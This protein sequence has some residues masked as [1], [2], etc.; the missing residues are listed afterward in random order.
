MSKPCHNSW[1]DTITLAFS[2]SP[3]M[4]HVSHHPCSSPLRERQGRLV[5][6]TGAATE[7]LMAH[8]AGAQVS[9]RTSTLP[10]RDA[11]AASLSD[12]WP[13]L[14]P[15]SSYGS[16]EAEQEKC[17]PLCTEQLS[18][19]PHGLPAYL[20]GPR[21]PIPPQRHWPKVLVCPQGQSA[22]LL[23]ES[24]GPGPSGT[25]GAGGLHCGTGR[26]SCA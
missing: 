3:L 8:R 2:L 22:V 18:S 26:G 11:A 1:S 13:P 6:F 9:A 7:S 5:H 15:H 14:L 24:R 21:D 23:R 19:R 20:G 25:G 16:H 10:H 4:S 12:P 17:G